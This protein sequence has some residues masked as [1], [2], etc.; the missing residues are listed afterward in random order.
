MQGDTIEAF[1]PEHTIAKQYIYSVA[2]AAVF[3]E[4]TICFSRIS[5]LFQA[6]MNRALTR[7]SVSSG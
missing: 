5:N 3:I 7:E 2:Y 6:D 1:E 4:Q